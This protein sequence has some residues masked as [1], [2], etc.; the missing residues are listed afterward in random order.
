MTHPRSWHAEW[1]CLNAWPALTSAV[2]DGWVLR[3]ANGLTRRANSA[4]PLDGAARLSGDT[5]QYFENLFRAVDL[6]LI[7]R[8]PTLLDPGVDAG[9]ERFGFAA[10]GESLVL[11][12]EFADLQAHWDAAVEVLSAPDAAWRDAITQLQ[13]R[14]EAQRA[15]YEDVIYSIVLPAGFASL[16]IEDE[17]V[18]LAYG[19]IDGDLL[20]CESVV[21]AERHRG[22]GYGR[23]LVA[24]LFGWA[25]RHHATAVCLQ[26]ETNN[27]AGIALYRSLGLVTELHRYHYRR[28]RAVAA[29][30][31]QTGTNLP[32]RR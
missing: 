3:F 22:R 25:Q 12:G 5:L 16:K 28:Q 20:C 31:F 32:G 1:G 15:T 6:P 11:Y 13:G 19:A 21:T 10:E 29:A 8:V 27:T 14:T 17:V 7:I 24:G 9:L 18:A 26:V 30:G 2:H 4:N 23:R